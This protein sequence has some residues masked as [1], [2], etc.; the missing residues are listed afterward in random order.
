ML[1]PYQVDVP[2]ERMPIANWALIGFTAFVSAV[3]LPLCYGPYELEPAQFG[4]WQVVTH[5]FI[6]G[7]WGH[8]I[9]NMVFL[10]V[11]GNAVNAKLGHFWFLAAYLSIGVGECIVWMLLGDGR[12]VIGAS[13]AIMG[14]LGIFFV[15]FP[16]NDVSVFYLYFF[17][18]GVFSISSAWLILFYLAGDLFWLLV[19]GNH[20]AVAYLC[21][22]AGALGGILLGTFLVA[23]GWIRSARGE[24]NLLEVMGWQEKEPQIVKRRRHKIVARRR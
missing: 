17:T 16:R 20:G 18:L 8:L 12:P 7:G 15:L 4:A 11:F 24:E 21:H 9:G 13:G 2:M 22:L 6:H 10:F 3:V 19:F 14:I 1:L 5:M 23:G